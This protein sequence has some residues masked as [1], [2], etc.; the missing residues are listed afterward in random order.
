MSVTPNY[1]WPLI[2]PTDF[3]TN[4]PADFEAFG[5]AVDTTLEAIE[6]KLDVITTE[7]DLVVGDSGGDPDRLPI[8]ALG[9]VLTSDGDTANWVFPAGGGSDANLIPTGLDYYTRSAPRTTIAGTSSDNV[10]TEDVTFY[11]PVFLPACTVNRIGVFTGNDAT[12]GNTTRLGIYENSVDNKPSTLL[13]D[14]GTINPATLN[15]AFEITISQVVDAGWYW[16]ALNRQASAGS[17]SRIC[18]FTNSNFNQYL[19]LI[20][21]ITTGSGD[22]LLGFDETGVTGAFTNAGTLVPNITR[23][24]AVFVRIG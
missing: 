11:T 6:T 13:L 24:P 4:L 18:G 23:I 9:T 21:A 8:G 22:R 7:G 5:D 14:A 2:E 3:V 20:G 1:N 19:P 15:T 10:P 16:L 12:T 17:G